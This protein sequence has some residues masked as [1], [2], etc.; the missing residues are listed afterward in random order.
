[1]LLLAN[2]AHIPTLTTGVCR[3]GRSTCTDWDT[4]MEWVS[5]RAL[6]VVFPAS[7]KDKNNTKPMST[8]ALSLTTT[9]VS[10][11][12]ELCHWPYSIWLG[13]RKTVE[14]YGGPGKDKRWV[15]PMAGILKCVKA[16]EGLT[17]HVDGAGNDSAPSSC[18]L[19]SEGSLLSFQCSFFHT[20][21]LI[22]RNTSAIW[23]NTAYIP[24]LGLI[25]LSFQF[26][27]P[28]LIFKLHSLSHLLSVN[29]CQSKFLFSSLSQVDLMVSGITNI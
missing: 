18:I 26:I 27:C 14:N 7:C 16:V 1:M 28:L 22:T 23:D 15:G 4:K 10:S 2:T 11:G 6:A 29:P 3:E 21:E 17:I 8:T 24:T 12:P 25:P 5:Q 19:S 13:V 9:L 20:I